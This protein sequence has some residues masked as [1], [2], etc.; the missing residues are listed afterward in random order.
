MQEINSSCV[1][2][3][4][5]TIE[6]LLDIEEST[7]SE[8]SQ[9]IINTEV[10]IHYLVKIIAIV[11]FSRPHR[12]REIVKLL[13]ALSQRDGFTKIF[14][15]IENETHAILLTKA[16]YLLIEL[17]AQ[18]LIKDQSDEEIADFFRVPVDIIKYKISEAIMYMNC[19]DFFMT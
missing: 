5:D 11:A 7:I 18:E 4:K 15:I 19:S 6:I 10:N 8:I 16:H 13:V 17:M 14:E 3:F 9:K 12:V 2:W 1:Y